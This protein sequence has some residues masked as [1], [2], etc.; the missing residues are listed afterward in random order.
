LCR[1][2]INVPKG[3]RT[4]NRSD[5]SA[6]LLKRQY[7]NGALHGAPGSA[8]ISQSL[9]DG[10]LPIPS[11]TWSALGVELRATALANALAEYHITN[12]IGATHEGTLILAVRP[13]QIN[14]YWQHGGHA[15]INAIRVD[16]TK[17]W[18]N[19]RIFAEFS[20]EP[21]T[22]TIADFDE[23]DIVKLIE[24]GPQQTA[25]TLRSG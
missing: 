5:I 8:A 6:S 16:G 19:D 11:V 12:R 10:S 14:P 22:V 21:E 1:A 17:V 13:V 24:N 4:A 23:G 3:E 15:A 20:R 7:T 25:R 18:V 2:N 9:V